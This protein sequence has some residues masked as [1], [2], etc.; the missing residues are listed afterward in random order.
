VWAI[1]VAAGRGERFGGPKQRQLI[2]GRSVVERSVATARDVCD[3]VVVVLPAGDVLPVPEADVTVPGGETRSASV[4]AGL[5]AVPL[6]ADVIVVHDAARPL[7]GADL[8]HAAIDA[9]RRGADAALCA[10]PVTDTVKRVDGER[11]VA[12]V[13]RGEIVAVQTPQ[14]FRAAILRRAHDGGRDAT[15]DGALVEAA[16]GTVVVVPGSP[17]NL[18]ITHPHDVVIAEALLEASS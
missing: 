6:D 9:I 7:A 16:G 4:R 13:D 2:G 10:V 17:A 14:A 1:V 3:G 18:K 12:T 5:A 8:W 15:D 11:V